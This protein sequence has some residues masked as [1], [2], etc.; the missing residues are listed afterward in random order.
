MSD[1]HI[2]SNALSTR[3]SWTESAAGLAQR[4]FEA[5]LPRTC[6]PQVVP[7]EVANVRIRYG[8]AR[9]VVEEIGP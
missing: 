2:D 4:F 3:S 8:L 7:I 9:E 5:C 1:L 6:K